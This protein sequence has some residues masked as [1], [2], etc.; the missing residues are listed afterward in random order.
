MTTASRPAPT[1]ALAAGLFLVTFA[2]LVL[3]VLD[4]RLLSVLT[5]YHLSF[6]AVSLAMLG[7][8]A[9]AVRWPSRAPARRSAVSMRGTCS[10]RRPGAWPSSRC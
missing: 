7:M 5:W 2:T 6:F 4:S 8:A 9:G 1:S 10:A 3:E